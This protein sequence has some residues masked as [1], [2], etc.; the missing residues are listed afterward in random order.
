MAQ[1][2]TTTYVCDSCGQAVEKKKDL[3]KFQITKGQWDAYEHTDLCLPC[4]G[5]FLKKASPFFSDDA[6]K[7]ILEMARDPA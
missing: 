6:A 3:R 1:I 2:R 5:E 7:E 4:E